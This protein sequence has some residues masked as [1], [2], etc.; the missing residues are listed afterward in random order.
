MTT[1]FFGKLSRLCEK[2][3]YAFGISDGE[4]SKYKFILI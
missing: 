3:N 4:L 1:Q 2:E